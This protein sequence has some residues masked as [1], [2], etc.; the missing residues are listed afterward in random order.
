MYVRQTSRRSLLSHLVTLL[1]R[2]QEGPTN[3]H[4]KLV[5]LPVARAAKA[6]N[7]HSKDRAAATQRE[8]KGG[9]HARILPPCL[10]HAS[11]HPLS[12]IRGKQKLKVRGCNLKVKARDGLGLLA[13]SGLARHWHRVRRSLALRLAPSKCSVPRLLLQVM[14]KRRRAAVRRHLSRLV[15]GGLWHSRLANLNQVRY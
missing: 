2:R 8:R 4:D 3:P 1:G 12:Y 5:H 14:R 10:T 13:L 15:T 6:P 7:W 11:S 9:P